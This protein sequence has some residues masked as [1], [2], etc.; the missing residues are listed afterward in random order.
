LHSLKNGTLGNTETSAQNARL[1]GWGNRSHSRLKVGTRGEIASQQTHY[2][3]VSR[4]LSSLRFDDFSSATTMD[5][6]LLKFVEIRWPR[7]RS[8][9][10]RSV[11]KF[12]GSSSL[13]QRDPEREVYSRGEGASTPVNL[14]ETGRLAPCRY[15][16][17]ARSHVPENLVTPARRP[18]AITLP[19]SRNLEWIPQSSS[20]NQ[21]CRSQSE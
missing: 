18:L 11:A 19:L 6:S 12:S 14:S 16:S 7:L 5:S 8:S 4:S 13:S 21:K 3:G 20:Y 2:T 9:A 17:I 1:R 10:R 15:Q